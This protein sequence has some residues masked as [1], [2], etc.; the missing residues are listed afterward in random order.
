M[1]FC[2]FSSWPSLILL[3]SCCI[4]GVG[5]SATRKEGNYSSG[6][7]EWFAW[8]EAVDITIEGRCA[9]TLEPM[10]KGCKTENCLTCLVYTHF[11]KGLLPLSLV[12]REF[13]TEWI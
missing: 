1:I 2:L 9:F 5:A 6:L 8:S 4:L 12:L 10:C 7:L 11:A 3:L 13:C